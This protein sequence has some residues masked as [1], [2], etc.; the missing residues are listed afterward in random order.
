M[1][2]FQEFLEARSILPSDREENQLRGLGLRNMQ[3]YPLRRQQ[4]PINV[5][6]LRRKMDDYEEKYPMSPYTVVL[7]IPPEA[8]G[9]NPNL[10]KYNGQIVALDRIIDNIHVAV[11]PLE[12]RNSEGISFY[13]PI[14]YIQLHKNQEHGRWLA[15][16]FFGRDKYVNQDERTRYLSIKSEEERIIL[17]KFARAIGEK[18]GGDINVRGLLN[19]LETDFLDR[20]TWGALTDLIEDY[21]ITIQGFEGQLDASAIRKIFNRK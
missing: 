11:S 18:A 16:S 21:G 10:Q 2:T 19:N 20:A 7:S 4:Q 12:G 8:T 5:E 9:V 1:Y 15:G 13:I 3:V 6:L 14:E 17:S